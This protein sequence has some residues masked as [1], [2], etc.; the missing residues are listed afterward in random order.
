LPLALNGLLGDAARDG[1]AQARIGI[2]TLGEKH[3]QGDERWIVSF[4]PFDVLFGQKF[5][6]KIGRQK[7]DEWQAGRLSELALQRFDLADNRSLV[8]MRHRRPPCG[9]GFFEAPHSDMRGLFTYRSIAYAKD[10]AIRIGTFSKRF[11]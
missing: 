6:K 10:S 3:C 8:R 1:L 4:A 9:N 11:G 5:L 2:L 7:I